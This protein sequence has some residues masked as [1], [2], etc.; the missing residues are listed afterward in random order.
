[1]NNRDNF[2]DRVKFFGLT[3]TR[4]TS[5]GW[6]QSFIRDDGLHLW[7]CIVSGGPAIQTAYVENGRF[8]GHKPYVAQGINMIDALDKAVLRDTQ[9]GIST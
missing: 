5:D 9:E 6:Y 8:V 3:I 7:R 1:M 4:T 2:N